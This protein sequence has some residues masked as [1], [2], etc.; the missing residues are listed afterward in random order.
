M[1]NL[2]FIAGWMWRSTST[3]STNYILLTCNLDLQR[4]LKV[5]GYNIKKNIDSIARISRYDNWFIRCMHTIDWKRSHKCG[6]PVIGHFI[7]Q[8]FI[9]RILFSKFVFI[10]C[11]FI[12]AQILPKTPLLVQSFRRLRGPIWEENMG[13]NVASTIGTANTRSNIN[14]DHLK[15][16][17]NY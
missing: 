8:Q 9:N 3:L 4:Y 13:N 11:F 16:W 17:C 5:L 7:G 2:P 14:S 15:D 6:G 1:S 10:W 12:I